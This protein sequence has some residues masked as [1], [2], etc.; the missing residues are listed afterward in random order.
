MKNLNRYRFILFLIVLILSSSF[1]VFA[2]G[3]KADAK[4]VTETKEYQDD[5][6]RVITLPNPILRVA[7][8][9]NTAS[10]IMLTFDPS[11]CVG[12]SETPTHN[13]VFAK[14]VYSKPVFGA[15][16]GKKA[17]LNKE[18]VITADPQVVID[19]GEIKAGSTAAM[20]NDLD[21]LTKQIGIPT[22]FIEN[23]LKNS[24]HTYR[25]LGKLLGNE[26]RGEELA[27]YA[28]EAVAFAEKVKSQIK[29]PRT[30]YYAS[31]ND[32]LQGFS[33][34]SFHTETLDIVGG[35]NA[36]DKFFSDSANQISLETI[37]K[38]DP[39]VIF[40]SSQEAYNVVMDKKGA[41]RSLKA[42]KNGDVY[43]IPDNVYNWIDAPP[44][45]NR[46]L[47]IYYAAEILY[48]EIADINIKDEA[49]KYFKLFYNYN[50][51]DEEIIL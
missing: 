18:A 1:S 49:K 16:Y 12:L 6:G 37:L 9:G 23:Y 3:K 32:G 15:F 41:W 51:K 13:T 10:V 34:G 31:S 14:E 11:L 24:G 38:R 36:I 40:L 26:K 45:V 43:V 2:Q 5:L 44:S 39:D 35:V 46:L 42:V 4:A 19:V 7:P 29:T 33:E 17:N 8:S 27:A 50:I 28:D 21:N 25:E 22:V 30:Y 48:P 47:G 20:A